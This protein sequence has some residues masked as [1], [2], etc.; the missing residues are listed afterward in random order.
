MLIKSMT[1]KLSDH[2]VEWYE[3]QLS[4]RLTSVAI[5]QARTDASSA[6]TDLAQLKE[7]TAPRT[8][9]EHQRQ[10]MLPLLEALKG[11]PV[12]FACRMMDGE[13]CD[14]TNEIAQFFLA[15]GCQ[16]PETIKT[17]VNDLPGSLAITL[18][19]TADAS[20]AQAVLSV[21]EAA[22]I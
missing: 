22:G 21:F 3:K 11:R 2:Y 20:V 10:A 16:V 7:K 15:A 1:R 6:R 18:H 8:L 19:G 4:S 5:Q 17:S 12:A 14:Y 13:S 9:S